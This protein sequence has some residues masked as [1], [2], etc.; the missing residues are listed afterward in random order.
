MNVIL[1]LLLYCPPFYELITAIQRTV[2]HSL[3]NPLPLLESLITFFQEF[4]VYDKDEVGDPLIPDYFYRALALHRQ[5]G[6]MRRGQQED[7]EEFFSLLLD[8]LHDELT[9]ISSQPSTTPTDDND[10][11]DG[12]MEV[13][14]NHRIAHTRTLTTRPSAISDIFGGRLRSVVRQPGKQ[15]SIT[16]EPYL[17]LQLD[18]NQPE[19]ESVEDALRHLVASESLEDA[20][21]TKQVFID[22][23]PIVLVLHLKRFVFDADLGRPLK[24]DKE[25][26]YP[27]D[28]YL[29][30]QVLSPVTAAQ[31]APHHYT[32]FGAAYH[33]GASA[34]GGHYTASVKNGKRWLRVDDT[35]IDWIR[36]EDATS[37]DAGPAYILLYLRN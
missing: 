21:S 33:H 9:R 11:D 17:A 23:L 1:Q 25:V 3:S 32:L 30:P 15:D 4:R 29:P 22:T 35:R 18:I 19:I 8:A 28:L 14:P 5:F 10:D 31:N 16:T 36:A 27:L 6:K 34:Q 20:K 24:M 37:P 7:A 12:W 26:L 2:V 13:G